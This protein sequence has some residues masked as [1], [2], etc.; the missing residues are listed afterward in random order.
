MDSKVLM[1]SIGNY[2]QSSGIDYDR[3]SYLKNDCV[4]VCIYIYMYIYIYMTLLYSRNW[5]TVI[6]QLHFNKILKNNKSPFI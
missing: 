1:Y 5:Y 4:Y 3:K 2:I 6:N